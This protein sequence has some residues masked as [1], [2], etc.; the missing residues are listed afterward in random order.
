MSL[1]GALDTAISGLNAQSAAFSNISDNVA[2]SQ[3]VGFKRVDTSFSDYLTDSTAELNDSGAVST[4][5]DYVN[6]VQG[7]VSQTDNPLALAINGQGFFS[8]NE[9]TQSN[10]TGTTFSPQQYYTRTGDFTMNASGYLVNSA[11]EYLDGWKVDATTGAV[12]KSATAPIQI[13]QTTDSPVATTSV[14]LSANLPATPSATATTSSQVSVYDNLGTP[15]AITLAWTQ[16]SA[17]D[18]T[19]TASSPD[20]TGGATIGT[21]EVKFG[22]ASGNAVPEGTVGSIG[23]A[24]GGLTAS[25]YAAGGAAPLALTA[26]FGSGSQTISLGLGEYGTA[27]GITQYAGTDY[28]LNGLTQ[29]GVP[30]GSFSSV[31]TTS[32]GDINVNYDNGKSVTVAQ[33]PITVFNAPDA[34]QSQSGQAFTQ[35]SGSGAAKVQARGHRRRGQPRHQLRR[36][37]QCRHRNGVHPAHRRPA[38][39][40]GEH[41][42]HHH[43]RRP[44]AADHRHEAL[45]GAAPGLHP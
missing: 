33:V 10:A 9:V 22:A 19:V 4:R 31:T 24:T 44:V 2:N 41:Q 12:D 40:F 38:R 23:N 5:P 14:S 3:T 35:T 37:L 36:G 6:S 13:S 20:A 34:L 1:F 15:H 25:T 42:G 30:P 11:G 7:T 29:N 18:W 21:A 39:L 43:L 45:S 32:A 26:N 8:V 17:N 28:T 16:N 27:T